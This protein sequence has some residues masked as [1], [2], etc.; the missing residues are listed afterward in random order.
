[1]TE[2]K[3]KRFWSRAEVAETGEDF[4]IRLDGRPVRT[5]LKSEVAMPSRALAEGVAAEWMAQGEVIDPLSMPLTRAVNAAIDKVRPQHREVALGLAGYAETD[6]LCYR[7]DGPDALIARQDAAWDPMLDWASGSL[8]AR[9]VTTAGI[10]PV[11]QPANAVEALRRR[12]MAL[13]EWELTALSEFVSL[14]GSF[15][16]GLAAMEGHDLADLW[17]RSRIDETWQI[18]RWGEDEDE[19]ARV[20]ARRRDFLQAGTYLSLLREG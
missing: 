6:L 10:L 11:A 7:A 1:M 16:L 5:P 4:A 14:S 20:A 3:T 17:D 8:G 19:A 13:S 12:A 2:W 9:L 18:D 15:V